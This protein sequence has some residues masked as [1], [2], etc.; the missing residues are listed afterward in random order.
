MF[1]DGLC[2]NTLTNFYNYFPS[3]PNQTQLGGVN[4]PSTDN[5]KYR[6]VSNNYHPAKLQN[7]GSNAASG[8]SAFWP[9]FCLKIAAGTLE[10]MTLDDVYMHEVTFSHF[11]NSTG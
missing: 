2:R 6:V 11:N 4:E 8:H 9:L 5:H 3:P 10:V 7:L 1:E